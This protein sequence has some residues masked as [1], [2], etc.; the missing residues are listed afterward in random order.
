MS[1]N[2]SKD[3]GSSYLGELLEP[4]LKSKL[5]ASSAAKPP[6]AD[7]DGDGHV[8]NF[9]K[10]VR[11]F[12]YDVR[13]LMKK[14]NIPVEKAYQMR[15]SKTKYGAEVIKTAKEK[16]GIKTGGPVA[17]ENERGRN[18]ERLYKI[19]IRYKN[20]T[21]YRKRTSQ[22]EIA[23]L[24]SNPNISS[25]EKTEYAPNLDYDREKPKLDPVGR[26]DSDVNNDGRVDKQD[27]YLMKRRST[28]GQ[29]IGKR[30]SGKMD[31]GFSNWRQ[32]LFEVIQDEIDS[33]EEKQIKEKKGIKNTIKI[34]PHISETVK[35]LGGSLISTEDISED[36]LDREYRIA[37]EYFY[38]QGLNENGVEILIEKLGENEFYK[39][40]QDISKDFTL[41]EWKKTYDGTRVISEKT[42]S[43]RIA[44]KTAKVKQ[45]DS[46]L[47]PK[48]MKKGILE[49]IVNRMYFKET[50]DEVEQDLQEVSPPGFKGTVKAMKKHGEIDNPFA[51]A[52][53][54]KKKGYKSHRKASGEMKEAVVDPSNTTTQTQNKTQ[55]TQQKTQQ[56]DLQQKKQQQPNTAAISKVLQARNRA[57]DAAKQFAN[58]QRTA[59]QKKIDVTSLSASYEPEGDLVD[60]ARA[61]EKRGFGSTGTERQRMKSGE[62]GPRG[63]RPV[64]SFSGGQNPHLRGK[65]GRTAEQRRASSRRYVDQPGGAYAGPESQ[66][67]KGRYA[68][69]QANKRDQ[70]HMHSR[71]D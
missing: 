28:I 13:H 29:A 69:M 44:V 60:E 32:D 35:D 46:M 49:S 6:A 16:L 19:V 62:S 12:I 31:E 65:Q 53:Y 43:R 26:E 8:D 2:L 42:K 4:K 21:T 59:A 41:L 50:I 67:G 52:W 18:D 61:E 47:S 45:S 27:S 36:F 3:R 14:N 11:Q 20:G 57:S 71:F 37:A 54:M 68:K 55:D 9:E 56:K 70:S 7:L 48:K 10:N 24:R 15:A 22:S 33:K 34:G 58:A 30:K 38:E 1:L 17:E 39:F 66:Q 63:R 51:L 23:K 40:V 64:T 5:K 25:V